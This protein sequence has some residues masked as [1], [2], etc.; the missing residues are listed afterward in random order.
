[1][2]RTD[3]RSLLEDLGRS[4]WRN[5]ERRQGFVVIAP[6]VVVFFRLVGGLGGRREWLE[7]ANIV[8]RPGGGRQVVLGQRCHGQRARLHALPFARRRRMDACADT[9]A[10]TR[11]QRDHGFGL[12]I[13]SSNHRPNLVQIIAQNHVK[14]TLGGVQDVE[15][16]VHIHDN[17][18]LIQRFRVVYALELRH[19]AGGLF[20]GSLGNLLIPLESGLVGLE[21]GQDKA[22]RTSENGIAHV[23]TVHFLVKCKIA[24]T[25]GIRAR[26][27]Y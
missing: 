6:R 3:L 27:R 22:R 21:V 20:N 12:D 13:A 26:Q 7:A 4:V 1:M 9:S 14:P 11:F 24:R 10:G 23:L 17:E 5:I 25:G 2:H 19:E 15:R 18:G 16:L 8:T